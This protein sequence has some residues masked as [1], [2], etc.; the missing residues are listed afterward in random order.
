M[1]AFCAAATMRSSSASTSFDS[2]SSVR[3][4]D[5][6]IERSDGPRNSAVDARRRRDRVDIGERGAGLDH[7]QRD[8]VVVAVREIVLLVGDAGE[9]GGAVRAPAA[10]A[11]RREFRRRGEGARVGRGV[12]HRRDDAFGA[13]IE[14]AADHRE[15]AE[16][17]AHDRRRAGLAHGGDAGREP[18]EVPQAVLR[19][20]VTAEK[21]SRA[22][23]SATIGAGRPHQPVWTVS[24]ARSRAASEKPG[25]DDIDEALTC[26]AD[27][28]WRRRRL[29]SRP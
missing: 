17:H 13:E 14:H 29:R 27:L 4:S 22:T 24:P 9:H 21:P 23:I 8:D 12:D 6:A 1:P 18:G 2:G 10:L 28:Y 16:R 11:D 7:R 25:S 15:V 26:M 19:S 20:S 5:S 3:P